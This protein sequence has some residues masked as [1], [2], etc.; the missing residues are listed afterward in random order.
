[1]QEIAAATSLMFDPSTQ[2]ATLTGAPELSSTT[3]VFRHKFKTAKPDLLVR[4]DVFQFGAG[5]RDAAAWTTHQT[6]VFR[7]VRTDDLQLLGRIL[8]AV[9]AFAA[10]RAA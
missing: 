6:P 5:L 7:A 1:M 9:A 2:Q 10:A 3:R 4:E 8:D